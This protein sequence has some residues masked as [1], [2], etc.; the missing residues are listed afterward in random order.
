MKKPLGNLWVYIVVLS[1]RVARIDDRT[2]KAL[3]ELSV[4]VLENSQSFS[5]ISTSRR[6]N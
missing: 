3:F 5:H 2:S 1:T 6:R 4:R